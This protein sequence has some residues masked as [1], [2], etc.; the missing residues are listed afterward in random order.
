[1]RTT[2]RGLLVALTGAVLWAGAAT[3]APTGGPVDFD[4]AEVSAEAAMQ[5]LRVIGDSERLERVDANTI[6]VRG[7]PKELE[8][9]AVVVELVDADD[10]GDVTT[11][12]TGDGSIVA[13]FDLKGVSS[14]QAV[15]HLR[16]MSI[17]QVAVV[18]EVS[19]L[20]VRGSGEQ[21]EAATRRMEVLRR[22]TTGR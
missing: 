2:N 10:S 15:R 14:R 22:E 21:I 1:V 9:A 3:S 12:E 11:R 4:L 16:T 6:R 18:H 7:T 8:V 20:L 19:A 13:R 5:A 17:R